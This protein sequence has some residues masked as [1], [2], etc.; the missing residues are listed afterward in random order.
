MNNEL[1]AQFKKSSISNITE[2]TGYYGAMDKSLKLFSEDD[3]I[4]GI[5]KTAWVLPGD[6]SF[7]YGLLNEIQPGNVAVIDAGG[8]KQL[9]CLSLEMIEKLFNAGASG[10]VVNGAIMQHV[11]TRLPVYAKS[12][13]PKMIGDVGYSRINVPVACGG[14]CIIPGDIIVGN[15]EG[16]ACIPAAEVY[17]VIDYC[18]MISN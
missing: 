6:D 8:N 16:L 12:V 9:A 10:I 7:F 18:K 15:M 4:F 2:A 3:F 11:D 14:K 1:I 13:H 17:Q 5:T